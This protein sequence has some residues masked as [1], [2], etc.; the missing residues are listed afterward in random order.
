M[1][2]FA[3]P[4]ATPGEV[5][6]LRPPSRLQWGLLVVAIVACVGMLA[7]TAIGAPHAALW[8]SMASMVST[9]TSLLE[10]RRIRR[11]P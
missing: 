1:N 5:R 9:V 4:R 8:F 7:A 3:S 11:L 6:K 10:S 2:P